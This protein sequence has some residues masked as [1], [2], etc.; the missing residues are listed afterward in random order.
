[1]PAVD[2]ETPRKM[3]P[4]PMT[5]P[6]S[7]P[8]SMTSRTSC[9]TCSR[10]LGAMPYFASP[11]SASPLSLS[12]MRLNRGGV[13]VAS[14]KLLLAGA[15]PREANV[16]SWDGQGA[17]ARGAALIRIVRDGKR[18][19]LGGGER[20]RRRLEGL[21]RRDFHVELRGG[22]VAE[23]ARAGEDARFEGPYGFVV[24]A[25]GAVERAA[26]L[27]EVPRGVGQPLVQLPS[28]PRDVAGIGREL[29]L[30]PAMGHGEEQREERGRRRQHHALGQG[31]LEK[32]VVV[33]E[34]GGE[35]RIVGQVEDY[36]LGA[37]VEPLPVCLARELLH[38]LAHLGSVV[39]QAGIAPRLVGGLG[40]VE[41]GIER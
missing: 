28:E 20:A 39:A 38:V 29:L 3:F 16:R 36:E 2:A 15:R 40:R 41:V 13:A 31:P 21:E 37:V 4:P 8:S 7:T 27:V 9:A 30:L 34:R 12:R 23:P 24:G 11:M 10:I 14:G 26:E 25:H 35:E 17:R 19:Q 1:M 18:A 5:M 32:L 33:L 6:I 22:E